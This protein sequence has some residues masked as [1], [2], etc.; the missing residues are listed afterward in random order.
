MRGIPI[1]MP[2]FF[3]DTLPFQTP[4]IGAFFYSTKKFK[5]SPYK[6]LTYP[7]FFSIMYI[8]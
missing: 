6:S 2:P 1:G 7:S 8:V 5:K 4:P 3:V